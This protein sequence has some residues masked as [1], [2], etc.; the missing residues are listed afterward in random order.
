MASLSGTLSVIPR[1]PGR[2]TVAGLPEGADAL[3]L[4]ELARTTGGQDILHVARDGQRLERLQD[5][6]RFFAPER[7]VLVFPAWDCLPYDRMSPH[8]DIVAE[9]LETLVR[10]AAPKKPGA[11][12]RIVL[13]SVGAALQ[14]VPPR[15]LYAEAAVVLKK[16]QT[17]DVNWLTKF[18]GEN[19][20]GRSETVMEPGEFAVR[21]GLVDLFPPGT[22]EPLRLDLFGDVLEEIRS[23]DPMSQ[24]STGPREEVVLLPVS[25]VLLTK[26]SIARF[27]GGYREL[28]GNATDDALYEAVSAGQR[29]VGMEHWLPLFHE[30]LE[31]LLDY[32][33]EAVVT[34][35][36]QIAEAFDARHELI[37]DYYDARLKTG[38]KGGMTG[39]ADYKPVP[40]DRL[41]LKPS[42]W[43]RLLEGHAVGQ[44][45]SFDAA[46]DAPN[47][48]DLAGRRHEGFARARTATGVNLFDVVA[49]H[50]KAANA[51]GRRVLVAGYTEG[52]A[53]RLQHLLQEHG[54]TTPVP[55]PDFATVQGLPAGAL[56]IAV[57]PVE[58]GFV[59]DTLEVIGEEDIIGDRLSRPAKKRRPSERFIA[60]AAA[61][62]EGDLVVHRE[63]GV[64][65]YEGLVTLEIQH[66]RHDCLRLTYEGGDK[67]FVPVENIDV[68]SRYGSAEEGAALDRLG[69]VAWQS[70]KAR[71]KQ[72]I[73]DMADRLIKIAAERAIRRGE[74]MSPPEGA[75]EEFCARF[76][77]AETD[78]QLQ[79]I[80]DVIDDMSSG[81]PMDRL[82]CGDVGFGKTEVALRAAFVAALSGKQVAVIAPT[83]LL[84][85][86]HHR[87]FSARFQGLPVRIG[88][89]SRLVPA[90]EAKAT[91]EAVKEGNV[92]IV[93]GTHALL[94][95]SIE[96]K[97]LG[98]LIVDEE[99]H[100]GVSHKERLKE[101]RAD[102][103]VLT[104]TATPIPRTLQLAL[105]GVRDMSLIATPPVDRLAVRTFVTPFDGVTIREAL[106]RE[107]YRGGQS[108]YVCP[109]IEDLAEVAANLRE[110]VP[111]IRMAM[112]HGKLA[113]TAIEN[114]M[115]DFVEGKFDV[116]LSTNIVESGL[117]ISTANTMVIHRADMFGLAQLYQ[118]RGRIG[119]GKTR[120]YAYL[121]VPPGKA[122]NEA[123]SKRLEVMQT[124]DTLGAGFQLASHDLDIRGAGNLL[125]EEQ[126]G[127]IREVGIELYQQLLEEAVEAARGQAREAERAEWSPQLNLGIPV[128]LP[129]EYIA[130]LSVRMGLYRRIG[131]LA[132]QAEIDSFAAELVDRFGKMPAEAEFLL[133]TVALKVLCR[134]A[135]VDRI[136]AGEKA[137]VLSLHDNK[138]AKP[139][140]LI[141]WLQKNAPLVR[142]RPDH[143][144]IVQRAWNDERQRLSGVTSIVSSLAKL[145]A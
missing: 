139:E 21:G 7:G 8:P 102:V 28:F 123:A 24:R 127:H 61:L 111:E 97:D 118:L 129:E 75:Y 122:L 63:H 78:D 64:G 131:A 87:T 49:E 10:L 120:A 74:T 35:D 65:R 48:I 109:R 4:A 84:A 142:L 116:L 44:F 107:Q 62:S 81:K 76:P 18:L 69:G 50:V 140:K 82:V 105:T 34:A 13:A 98:L 135:G 17:L 124:L 121:T 83:T 71:L 3:A 57:W 77:Y 67:L 20:Y 58:H 72:R 37:T 86:Q 45:T 26:D 73:A 80:S 90:K 130:D 110:L 31:T 92:D 79:A 6:L 40:P 101:L 22:P 46:P 60:E 47:T 112:A 33:S 32:C 59:L 125:G 42:E 15:S 119:R 19:G 12:A 143:R 38:G 41:Y 29:H 56:G 128:L 14:K 117:D 93:V 136:D 11:P 134:A 104:L 27:R 99:Q 51:A 137:V 113:P 23:F 108:F 91:K 68:L 126:S 16:G 25:E 115:Q 1:K 54:A 85:R 106:L 100:F 9:R 95:K 141:A 145:A 96:F 138:F 36:H 114:T 39:A 55:V 88:R 43:D 52:S 70:R 89:L 103:H 66:A 133:N 53:S 2:W 94:A 144:V 30:R 5:G 132:D